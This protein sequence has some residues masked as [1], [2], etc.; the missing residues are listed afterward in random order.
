MSFLNGGAFISVTSNSLIFYKFYFLFKK[1]MIEHLLCTG[2]SIILSGI[3]F[4]IQQTLYLAFTMYQ[5]S[6]SLILLRA[7]LETKFF[8]FPALSR[9]AFSIF[10]PQLYVAFVNIF[11]LHKQHCVLQFKQ[12]LEFVR[13][14]SVFFRAYYLPL[15]I[16]EFCFNC[17]NQRSVKLPWTLY[18]NTSIPN[19]FVY[20]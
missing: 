17:F 18:L 12:G 19:L 8:P 7:K 1:Y 20:I 10:R 14:F 4:Y 6:L 2:Y 15:C 11:P 16:L 13:L 3:L 9:M 5:A